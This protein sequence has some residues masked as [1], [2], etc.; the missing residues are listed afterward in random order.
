MYFLS[1]NSWKKDLTGLREILECVLLGLSPFNPEVS[2]KNPKI[3]GKFASWEAARKYARFQ[4]RPVMIQCDGKVGRLSP[5]GSF[6]DYSEFYQD[7]LKQ[8]EIGDATAR[9]V[10]PRKSA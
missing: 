7:E 3:V 6:D 5:S 10:S 4:N 2:M 8:M 9:N 1:E